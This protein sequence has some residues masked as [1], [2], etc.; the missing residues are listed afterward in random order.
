MAKYLSVKHLLQRRIGHGDY[1]LKEFPTDR[2][3][4]AEFECDTRTARKAVAELIQEGLLV[5]QRNGRPI[6]NVSLVSRKQQMRVALL[7]VGYP[8]PFTARWQRALEQALGMRG[9]LLRPVSYR[10]MD[11]PIVRDTLEGFD[12][13]FFGLPGEDP[14]DHLLRAIARAERPV[15]FLDGDLSKHGFPS[16][17]L[18]APRAITLLLNHLVKRGHQKV[19][20]LNTQPHVHVIQERF[21]AWQE[22]SSRGGRGGR[23]IDEPVASF[24]SPLERAYHAA[25]RALDTGGFDA[26]ALLCCTSAAAKGV[27]RA[28]HDRGLKVGQDLA[29]CSADDGAGEAQYL[30][31]SLTSLQDPDPAPY[32]SVCLDWIERGGS[33]WQGPL[34]VQPK[35]VPIF[36]GESTNVPNGHSREQTGN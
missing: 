25:L 18:A 27:Y 12:G 28:L 32:L 20:W 36:L 9:G 3:L 13:V 23:V 17:W 30:V 19:A 14:T 1:L 11:D 4:S 16:I 35:H 8:T 33:D 29:V 22:W 21:A 7:T 5:R 34:L 15:V 31:P 10:H 2:E 24:E 26:S 6:V